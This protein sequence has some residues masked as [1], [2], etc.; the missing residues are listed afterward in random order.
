M[1]IGIVS[2]RYAKAL[3]R[4]ATENKE[5]QQVYAEMETLSNTFLKVQAL[6]PALLN[7]VLTND[8]KIELLA[9]ACVGNGEISSSSKRFIQLVT[10]K[11]RADLMLFIANAYMTL[12]RKAKGIIKGCLTVPTEISENICKRLQQIIENKT[13]NKVEFEVRVDEEIKGGFILDYDTYRLD[14]SLR[15]QLNE[16]KRA[17]Q[18]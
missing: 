10:E 11:K 4:F 3:L 16:L 9:S 14:A 7:P 2:V 12:Y 1:D 5:E 17:L 18:N 8:Q 13:S 15:T 6:Q